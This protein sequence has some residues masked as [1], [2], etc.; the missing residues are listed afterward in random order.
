MALK[1][2]FKMTDDERIH[3]SNLCQRSGSKILEQLV[4]S[5]GLRIVGGIA[6]GW[7]M[8]LTQENFVFE[9]L[10]LINRA[11]LEATIETAKAATGL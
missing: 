9:L 11:R 2:F 8:R 4:S 3:V 7:E 10:L 6:H 1:E 5:P